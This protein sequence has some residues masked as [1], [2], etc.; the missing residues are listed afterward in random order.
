[1]SKA[2]TIGSFLILSLMLWAISSHA[3]TITYYAANGRP[4]T[5]TE[6]KALETEKF[7]DLRE[8]KNILTGEVGSQK[9]LDTEQLLAETELNASS[10]DEEGCDDGECEDDEDYEDEEEFD[11]AVVEINDPFFPLNYTFFN[12]NDIL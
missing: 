9:N 4:V 12:I 8:L 7:E 11:D 6:Y 1:M 3:A 5:G 2:V 10:S